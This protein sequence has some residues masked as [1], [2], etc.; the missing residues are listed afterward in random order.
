MYSVLHFLDSSLFYVIC[1]LTKILFL[2]RTLFKKF[3][4]NSKNFLNKSGINPNKNFFSTYRSW[5]VGKNHHPPCCYWYWRYYLYHFPRWMRDLGCRALTV[6]S[7]NQALT[8]SQ[9]VSQIKP[10][11]LSSSCNQHIFL[12][13]QLDHQRFDD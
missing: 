11:P 5:A 1:K 9:N 12:I 4:K 13:P 6:T 7:L 10:N 2:K 8:I 3:F